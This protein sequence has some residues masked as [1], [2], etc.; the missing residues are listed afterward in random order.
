MNTFTFFYLRWFRYKIENVWK[1]NPLVLIQRRVFAMLTKNFE[2]CIRVNKSILR[3][4]SKQID[5]KLIIGND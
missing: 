4:T 2:L 5:K 3:D 1:Y